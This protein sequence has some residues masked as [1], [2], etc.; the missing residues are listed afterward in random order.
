M[1]LVARWLADHHLPVLRASAQGCPTAG[2]PKSSWGR[3]RGRGHSSGSRARGHHRG[4]TRRPSPTCPLPLRDACA[5]LC[6]RGSH[7]GCHGYCGASGSGLG[8]HLEQ[9]TEGGCGSR[10]GGGEE[11]DGVRSGWSARGRDGPRAWAVEGPGRE[12]QRGGRRGASAEGAPRGC[13]E[14]G[15][16]G[17]SKTRGPWT[18]L[19]RWSRRQAP[20]S[21]VARRR[22]QHP[23]GGDHARAEG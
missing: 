13:G 20:P 16:S 19:T 11:G 18:P 8:E 12:G 3:G 14:G 21:P 7:S 15:P 17:P 4:R 22:R 1:S 6:P 9:G 23:A 5:P 10:Q 2:T